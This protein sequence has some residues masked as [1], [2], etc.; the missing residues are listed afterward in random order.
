MI[1]RSLNQDEVLC[2]TQLHH[3]RMTGEIARIWGNASFSIPDF[4]E[5]LRTA[6]LI[7]DIGWMDWELNPEID[8]ETGHP[9]DFLRMKQHHHLRIWKEGLLNS[10]GFGML[11]ALLV[12][13]HNVGLASLKDE[14]NPELAQFFKDA[15]VTEANL[16]EKVAN[17]YGFD[18]TEMKAKLRELN[19]YLLLWDYISLR[20]CM[21]KERNP[22]GNPPSPTQSA[23]E[24]E[25]HPQKEDCF[26]M[27]PWPFGVTEFRWNAIGYIHKKGTP[28]TYQAEIK[29]LPLTLIPL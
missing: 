29:K 25:P 17:F 6:S 28:F 18:V 12:Y 27:S 9:F 16:T 11:P 10:Y 21:G 14:D 22:F 20:M 26:T 4:W 15:S 24:I 13:R 19:R 1:V 7:H 8:S 3:S 2:I 5:E 23:F